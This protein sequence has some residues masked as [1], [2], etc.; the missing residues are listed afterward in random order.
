MSKVSTARAAHN[1]GTVHE[2][3][4]V[5]VQRHGVRDRGRGEARPSRARIEFGTGVEEQYTAPRTV[6]R[7]IVMHVPVLA[8]E[9]AL[10]PLLA[11]DVELLRRQL[12]TP[13]LLGA[14]CGGGGGRIDTHDWSP[15]AQ[16]RGWFCMVSGSAR[17]VTPGRVAHPDAP[18]CLRIPAGWPGVAGTARQVPQFE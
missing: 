14:L 12:L 5:L 7:A 10:R 6:I 9:R 3:A 13:L 2:E 4:V 16:A 8:G 18:E 1:F 11:K 15:S 17:F